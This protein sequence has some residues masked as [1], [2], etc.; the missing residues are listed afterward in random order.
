STTMTS[1]NGKESAGHNQLADKHHMKIYLNRPYTSQDSGT[2]ENR[3][4][5]IRRF[6][7]KKKDLNLVSNIR[8]KQIE[9]LMNDRRVRRFG[10]ISPIEKLKSTWPVA[11]IT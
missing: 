3:I 11:L 9:K 5:L 1:V 10:Y 8:I 7:P 2:V 6:L 4:G